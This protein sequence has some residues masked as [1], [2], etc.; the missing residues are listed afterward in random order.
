MT[1]YLRQPLLVRYAGFVCRCHTDSWQAW[2]RWARSACCLHPCW[3]VGQA[4]TCDVSSPFLTAQLFSLPQ[5]AK[6]A[7]DAGGGVLYA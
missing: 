7:H 3:H 4:A 2:R 5:A 1:A 6:S